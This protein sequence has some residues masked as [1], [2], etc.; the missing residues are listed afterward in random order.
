MID[1]PTGR[2]KRGAAV[3]L[4]LVGALALVT[5]GC[6]GQSADQK[7]LETYANTVCADIANWSTQVKGIAT[8]FSGGISRASL[9][10]KVAQVESATKSLAQKIKA[11]P[12]P[13]TAGGQA[14]KQQLQQLS[15]ELSTTAASAKAV[16]TGLQAN[17]SAATVAAAVLTVAPQVKSLASSAQSTVSTLKSQ[18]GNV[19]SAFKSAESCKSLS[20]GSSS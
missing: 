10:S 13:N 11:V 3:L 18:K 17:A 2:R 9:Q 4:A 7:A 16:V 8:D 20:S 14:A 15:T 12:A 19:S 1:K 5:A 6:G